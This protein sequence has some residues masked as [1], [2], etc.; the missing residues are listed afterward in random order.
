MGVPLSSPRPLLQGMFLNLRCFQS[1]VQLSTIIAKWQPSGD[2]EGKFP[3]TC[4][5]RRLWSFL[6]AE[7]SGQVQPSFRRWVTPVHICWGPTLS[8][9]ELRALE[10]FSNPSLITTPRSTYYGDPQL[11][12]FTDEETEAKKV[13]LVAPRSSGK[14]ATELSPI[15]VAC[16]LL[17]SQCFFFQCQK[18]FF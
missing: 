6:R 13:K 2:D 18:I 9:A 4:P 10:V 7:T 15:S 11:L 16:S 14:K 3:F 12:H 1:P 5:S 8:G 17:F